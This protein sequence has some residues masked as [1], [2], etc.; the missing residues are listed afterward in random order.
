M[1][2]GITEA[3]AIEQID[4]GGP[5]MLRSAAKN[6]ASVWAVADPADYQAVLDQLAQPDD[7]ICFSAGASFE[8]FPAY[9]RVRHAN[10]PISG[11]CG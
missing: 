2:D 8:S 10:C 1:Q 5:S 11:T 7:V 9:G 4:I 3:E 6:F